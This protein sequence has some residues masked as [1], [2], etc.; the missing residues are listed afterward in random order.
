MPQDQIHFPAWNPTKFAVAF[1]AVDW[2][3]AAQPSRVVK[4]GTWPFRADLPKDIDALPKRLA[5][6]AHR[7]L[8]ALNLFLST[9]G[10]PAGLGLP[11]GWIAALDPRAAEDGPWL[12]WLPIWPGFGDAAGPA[13]RL[14]SWRLLHADRDDAAAPWSGTVM[15]TAAETTRAEDGALINREVGLRVPMSL[16]AGPDRY[17]IDVRSMTAELPIWPY[18]SWTELRGTGRM[19]DNS[20]LLQRFIDEVLH[21]GWDGP[22]R[23][24]DRHLPVLPNRMRT[25]D[26]RIRWGDTETEE[27]EPEAFE[28]RGKAASALWSEGDSC[29]GDLPDAAPVGVGFTAAYRLGKKD[30]EFIGGTTRRLST[31]ATPPG[32]AEIMRQGPASWRD[33]NHLS[34]AG[35]YDWGGRRPGRTDEALNGFRDESEFLQPVQGANDIA[36]ST[37]SFEV[38][39]CPR[40]VHEDVGEGI[41]HVALPGGEQ[42]EIRRNDFSALMAYANS[43]EVFRIAEGVDIDLSTLVVD[44]QPVIPVFYRSGVGPG[45]GKDGQTVNA[46][47]SIVVEEPDASGATTVIEVHLALADLWRRAR[48]LDVPASERWAQPL[49]IAAAEPWIWHEFG[50]VLIA[51][52]LGDLELPF[53]H[54]IG[55]GL[56]AVKAD[57]YSRLADPRGAAA[58]L[59]GTGDMAFPQSLRGLTFPWV[60]IPRRHDRSVALGWAWGGALNRSLLNAPQDARRDRKGYV[61]EQILSSTLF[62]LYRILGGDTVRTAQRIPHYRM[63]ERASAVTLFLAMEAVRMLAQPPSRAE[64][65]EEGMEAADTARHTPL[66]LPRNLPQMPGGAQLPVP[67]IGGR[68]RKVVRWAFEAQGLYAPDPKVDHN[69]PGLPPEVDIYIPDQRPLRERTENGR[70]RHGPGGYVPV[71]LDWDGDR[72][73]MADPVALGLE[74]DGAGWTVRAR[75]GNRGRVVAGNIGTRFWLGTA[76]GDIAEEDWMFGPQIVWVG[77]FAGPQAATVAPATEVD[78]T[79]ELAPI[80]PGNALFLLLLVEASCPDD[81]ANSDA[82]GFLATAIPAN[83]KPPAEPVAVADLVAN[84]NNLGLR[85]IT[86]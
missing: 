42:P 81:R 35:R 71:S 67:W 25:E 12:R 84:D 26:I 50:H 83:G 36:L 59:Y 30:F 82:A 3:P 48:P 10:R 18:L 31:H 24:L 21:L 22:P 14:A 5:Q 47:V 74:R 75:V 72:L 60:F 70:V 46:R 32:S 4:H 65:L 79:H 64:A 62:R 27:P 86:L 76:A 7:Y 55:D 8:E 15:M 16:Q 51:A 6:V 44:A 54:S 77:P 68:A 53:V 63:R 69:A 80:D 1:Q 66:P 52:R 33:L 19:I 17:R 43:N 58:A 61:G 45:P 49:G 38:R 73:W 85:M 40:F 20:R 28:L 29:G 9:D 2:P 23:D 37:T 78:V 57:P 39:T 56:A 41:K 34:V 13:P 11:A